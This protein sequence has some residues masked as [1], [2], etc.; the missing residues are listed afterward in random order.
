MRKGTAFLFHKF[1]RKHLAN[2]ASDADEAGLRNERNKKNPFQTGG[3]LYRFLASPR[4]YF[5]FLEPFLSATRKDLSRSE[6]EA[7][8]LL[9]LI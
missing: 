2:N 9:V 1:K 7:R 6:N 4:S 3:V 8:E 5:Y